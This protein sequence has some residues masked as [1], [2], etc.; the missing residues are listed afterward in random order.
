MV[1]YLS[2]LLS[3]KNNLALGNNPSFV[4]LFLSLIEQPQIV[5]LNHLQLKSSILPCLLERLNFKIFKTTSKGKKRAQCTQSK[6]IQYHN[7]IMF[8]ISD[9][10]TTNQIFPVS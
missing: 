3:F 5:I 9:T 8:L 2:C 1:C 10:T 4:S 7:Y 6:E